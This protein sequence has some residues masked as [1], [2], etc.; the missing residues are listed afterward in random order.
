M[1]Q[2]LFKK[3]SK[4]QNLGE[5]FYMLHDQTQED[6]FGCFYTIS[7]HNNYLRKKNMGKV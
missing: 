1:G 4:F 6:E 7:V 2:N 3:H 5:I